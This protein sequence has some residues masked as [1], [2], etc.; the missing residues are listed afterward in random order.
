MIKIKEC[1]RYIRNICYIFPLNIYFNEKNENDIVR[2]ILYFLLLP[3][4]IIWFIG[5][6]LSGKQLNKETEF[7]YNLAVACIV[8]NEA[9]YLDEWIKYH[10]KVCGVDHF[11]MYNNNSTDNTVEV[12]NKYIQA[13]LVTLV[14][15]PGSKRQVDAYNMTILKYR[16]DV[17][18]LIVIDADEFIQISDDVDESLYT[19]INKIFQDDKVS[20]LGINWCMF[21]S[22]HIEK[23]EPKPVIE[24]FL[25]AGQRD[26]KSNYYIKSIINPR[27]SIGFYR[28]HVCRPFPGY[29][30]IDCLGNKLE[31]SFTKEV[32]HSPIRLNHYFTKSK[33]EFDLKRGRGMAD[34]KGLR[35]QKNFE[36]Y[37]MND[38]YDDSMI[39]YVKYV[40]KN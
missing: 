29:K 9:K 30:V 40:G 26:N 23:Y 21:G 35:E 27:L 1:A 6:Y 2:V 3:I 28:A 18:Y 24:R 31:S 15:F 20:T 32:I 34:Q 7:K 19:I 25:Y 4:E 12:L 38:V 37:D 22:S 11:F 17:K 36:M 13:G 8:K 10:N 33:E 5:F 16:K 39:K 14:D